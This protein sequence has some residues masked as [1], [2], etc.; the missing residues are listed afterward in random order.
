MFK[1]GF[2]YINTI[3]RGGYLAK[4]TKREKCPSKHVCNDDT[5]SRAMRSKWIQGRLE[6]SRAFCRDFTATVIANVGVVPTYA[7]EE[8][9]CGANV[10]GRVSSACSCLPAPTPRPV[11]T[12]RRMES[13]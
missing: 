12:G 7:A 3:E 5:C 1:S 8:A 11:P 4:M 2:I 6:E 13:F 10:I 9:A